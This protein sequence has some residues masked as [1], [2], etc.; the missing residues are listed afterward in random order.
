MERAASH[1]DSAGYHRS[2][3]QVHIHPDRAPMQHQ[4]SHLGVLVLHCSVDDIFRQEGR[5][6]KFMTDDGSRA[7]RLS[8]PLGLAS[9]GPSN[10]V[11]SSH[12]ISGMVT[13]YG[14]CHVHA[15][16]QCIFDMYYYHRNPA[17][18][19]ARVAAEPTLQLRCFTLAGATPGSRSAPPVDAYL[20]ARTGGANSGR[21]FGQ[22]RRV[23]AA[24][25]ALTRTYVALRSEIRGE[26][27]DLGSCWP[28][29]PPLRRGCNLATRHL[30]RGLAWAIESP[31]PLAKLWV[32]EQRPTRRDMQLRQ[33]RPRAV[34]PVRDRERPPLD[35]AYPHHVSSEMQLYY[36][37]SLTSGL[38]SP[39]ERSQQE[40]ESNMAGNRAREAPF[41]ALGRPPLG[42][43]AIYHNICVRRR[44]RSAGRQGTL[45][46]NRQLCPAS[47]AYEG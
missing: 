42:A 23:P 8:V 38:S 11:R 20:R 18:F 33:P 22:A 41:R 19:C 3:S 27:C 6:P 25:T 28:L 21:G 40:A 37:T 26:V 5:S 43:S 44:A 14:L 35:D 16:S 10:A 13:V 24:G 30:I 36:S 9:T 7:A 32:P 46:V 15:K 31:S 45:A 39:P 12:D 29:P 34:E 2:Q 47:A 17:L 1:V 4:A